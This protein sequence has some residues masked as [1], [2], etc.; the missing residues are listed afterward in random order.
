MRVRYIDGKTL[1][2]AFLVI[3]AQFLPQDQ[4]HASA[5]SFHFR[6]PALRDR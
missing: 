1:L 6:C 5:A 3:T 2:T 4:P